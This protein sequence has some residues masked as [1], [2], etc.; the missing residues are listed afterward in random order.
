MA[1]RSA[2][3]RPWIGFAAAVLA[4][5]V[6]ILL[7]H[8]LAS[9]AAPPKVSLSPEERAWLKANPDKLQL[10]FNTDFPPIEYAADDGD[11]IGMGADVIALI[12]QRLGISFV[13]T[14]STDWNKHLA[15]LENGTCAIA[16]TIVRTSE[17]ERY[18]FFTAP[19]ATA[20]VVLITTQKVDGAIDFNTLPGRRMAVVS[21]YATERYLRELALDRFDIVPV[22]SV[23]EGLRALSFGQVDVFAENQ[24]VAA[25]HI[26][27]EGIADLRVAG[28]TDYSF[29]W[30]IGVSRRYPLLFSAID[31]ALASLTEKE[32]ETVRGRWISL[33]FLGMS[34]ENWR[35]L[36][37]VAVFTALLLVGL[38]L[39]S[40]VLKRQLSK[41]IDELEEA[42]LQI[43]EQAEL[44]RLA[45]ETT[46]AGIW[47]LQPDRGIRYINAPWHPFSASGEDYHRFISASEV[48]Q[49]IHPED[50]PRVRQVYRDYV[51]SGGLG[52]FET[53][54]RLHDAS[55]SWLWMLSKGKAVAWDEQGQ[56]SRM[57]GLDVN[58]QQLK[59]AQE[60]L[61]LSE[62]RFRSL[63]ELA[64]MPLAVLHP[65]D[66]KVLDLNA[67]FTEVLGYTIDDLPTIDRW[68]QLAYPEIEY[69]TR[70]MAIWPE[71]VKTMAAKGE[72]TQ[73]DEFRVTCKDGSEKTM[74]AS[75]ASIKGN[76]LVSLFD[77]T[78]RKRAEES[79]DRER[80]N[81]RTML[82]AIPVGSAVFNGA[83]QVVDVNPAL[84]R[85][86]H[87]QPME[88]FGDR[89]GDLL[90]CPNRLY[91]PEGC[92][93]SPH[94]PNCVFARS[95][96]EALVT[97][98]RIRDREAEAMLATGGF[99]KRLW[100][101]FS[102]EPFSLN[103]EGHAIMALTDITER[104]Q[105]EEALLESER[106]LRSLFA[107]MRELIFIFNAEGR[108]L[109]IAPTNTA[110]LYRPADKQLGRTLGEIFPPA[111][112]DAFMAVIRE[113]LASRKPILFE[114]ELP[115]GERVLPFEA[116]VSPLESDRVMW[117]ARDVSKRK[118]GELE[119]LELQGQL[120]QAQKLEAVGVL[121]GG[122]AH[123]FN[124]M[125]GAIIGYGE[126]TLA[127]MDADSPHRHN[128]ERILDAARRS[129]DLTRQLLAFARK[130]TVAPV[131]LDL[132]ESIPKTLTMLRRLI[133]ENITLV[134][135]PWG[136]SCLVR[137]DPTQLDQIL[138]NLC[139][140]AR[141]AVGDI[142][143]ITIRTGALRL[144]EPTS[145]VD[146]GVV[147]GEYICLS[148][149]DDGRGMD[150]ETL[151]HIFEP[152]FTTKGVGQ[153]TGLGL[154][155]VYGIVRQNDGWIEVESELETGT[156]FR[157]Y[158]RRQSV[159]GLA[160]EEKPVKE[161][162]GS[163]GETVLLVE[164]D[165]V[166][167]EMSTI[168]LDH[169]GYVVLTAATPGEAIRLAEDSATRIDLL[170][171][172]MVMPE[173]NGRVLAERLERIRPGMPH[174]FMSGY[175]SDA[176]VQQGMLDEGVHFIQKP[177]SL[178]VLAAKIRAVLEKS[179]PS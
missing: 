76:L 137:M 135:Q 70:L 93:H 68:W 146:V 83:G 106:K 54:F 38:G 46:Q 138:A 134:W 39:I 101:R 45:T 81:L 49:A 17:R 61:R 167:L 131:I 75:A 86:F 69:R 79:L 57:I 145:R 162:P 47:D 11:F 19:Y 29:A 26:R 148:V 20:P 53:E 154:A 95:I 170:L 74:L 141:D 165:P 125:L 30:S 85:L 97:Q 108:Y 112:A 50:L 159:P 105:F 153:G 130:Q 65:T 152:F 71:M 116:T 121:A 102:I 7:G 115:I 104:K 109:E 179:Q 151:A 66:G 82:H 139:V 44:L 40:Y 175:T 160:A 3:K 140:N 1:S 136:E 67:R 155:T 63:F 13:K 32:L 166:L 128:I 84:E 62:A 91:D 12:E 119:R 52:E 156:T 169:L 22:A 34:A 9:A 157:V 176:I 144:D 114:Y 173:M 25:F 24:A 124:N 120:L 58:I 122:V 6:W 168:M 117:V 21:G 78:E 123:D 37:T 142:G 51:G 143:R 94:C 133:G 59:E 129:A 132:N 98:R 163:Q 56:P 72:G 171:T 178:Q 5:A 127:A 96:R 33:Q 87:C 164:D 100:L 103:G 2:L 41:K 126:L 147:C 64:P 99:E 118:E 88:T 113:V 35:L 150:K 36:Q 107:T 31:K 28:S 172:D 27:R 60:D 16:P 42:R 161:I 10:W 48:N 15:A 18:A 8:G 73:S 14:A 80:N 174:L 149:S 90:H 92:G 89:F 77:I 23:A 158:L 110:L 55:G 177:F 43:G 111:Q 4:L